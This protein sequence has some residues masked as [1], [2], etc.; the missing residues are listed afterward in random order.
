MTL[1]V[2]V[3]GANGI[4]SFSLLAGEKLV[5]AYKNEELYMSGMAV[6]ADAG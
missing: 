1:V 5:V 4:G 6:S 2:L 3:N